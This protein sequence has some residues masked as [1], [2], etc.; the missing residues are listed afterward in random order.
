MK[1]NHMWHLIQ[2]IFLLILNTLYI[3]YAIPTQMSMAL[4]PMRHIYPP[5]LAMCIVKLKKPPLFQGYLQFY[6]CSMVKASDQGGKIDKTRSSLPVTSCN[7]GKWVC[8]CGQTSR[9]QRSIQVF[10]LSYG[11]LITQF[12]VII[13]WLMLWYIK[14]IV[15]TWDN[16]IRKINVP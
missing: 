14:F 6:L 7:R 1:L 9:V 13:S 11:L 5:R 3:F 15:L 10:N 2:E 12:L 4:K 8:L 16:F